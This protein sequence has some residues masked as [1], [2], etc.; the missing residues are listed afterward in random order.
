MGR[1]HLEAV[2]MCGWSLAGACDANEESLQAAVGEGLVEPSAC[3]KNVDELLSKIKPDLA[4]VSTPADFHCETVCKAAVAGV[5]YILCEKPMAVS[6]EECDRMI[7]TCE[8]NNAVLGVNY[9]RRFFK[10][11]QW[12]KK[13]LQSPQ[14]GGMRNM[15]VMAGNIGMCMTGTHFIEVFAWFTKSARFQVVAFLE[16]DP[17]PNPRGAH[18]R[19]AVGL[20][21][22][23]AESGEVLMISFGSD[24]GH[25]ISVNYGCQNGWMVTD[26]MN[27]WVRLCYRRQEDRTRSSSRYGTPSVVKVANMEPLDVV[28]SSVNVMKA[29]VGGGDF[30]SGKIGRRMVAILV[31]A[32]LSSENGHRV[33]DVDSI[34]WAR[35]RKFA[36][37]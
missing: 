28:K 11:F 8:S 9:G 36:W 24:Q 2:R 21:R 19:D 29:L 27:R 34:G 4:I 12:I 3:F 20:L 16:D 7:A 13:V 6:L 33:L 23:V 5:K 18:Y 37:A 15:S 35:E 30:P 1:R 26:E 31:A 22:L 10:E 14:M 25:G 32:H 17:N